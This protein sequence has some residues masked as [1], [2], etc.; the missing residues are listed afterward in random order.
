MDKVEYYHERRF[1][2]EKS[3]RTC[4]FFYD[5]NDPWEHRGI[6]QAT[7]NPISVFAH[8]GCHMHKLKEDA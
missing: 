4:R 5:Q 2:P 7:P 1:V 6:C 8:H 3:C